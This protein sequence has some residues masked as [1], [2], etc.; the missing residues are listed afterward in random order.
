MLRSNPIVRKML[1]QF[2]AQADSSAAYNN[3]YLISNLELKEGVDIA[4]DILKLPNRD[5]HVKVTALA[6]LGKIGGKEHIPE[7]E[8]FL[9]DK[10]N[11]GAVRFG[12]G[13]Q[14]STQVRDVAL[15]TLIQLTGQQMSDYNLPYLKMFPA[16][17]NFQIQMSPGMLG[18]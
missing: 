2:L 16:G 14:I 10:T 5:M 6:L 17:V 3:L 8:P 18:F 4:R 15:A 7:V 12:N 1:V 13:P 9:Q 11:F